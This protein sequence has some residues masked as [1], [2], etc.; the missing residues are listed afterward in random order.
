M[1]T[2][3][4]VGYI[5]ANSDLVVISDIYYLDEQWV[6]P[7][8]AREGYVVD[9][10][11]DEEVCEY[12]AK[13]Q[14]T[15]AIKQ[16]PDGAWRLQLPDQMSAEVVRRQAQDY[17]DQN[18]AKVTIELHSFGTSRLKGKDEC[19]KTGTGMVRAGQTGFAA[20]KVARGSTIEVREV[21]D[22]SGELLYVKIVP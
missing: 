14:T 3:T 7:G 10:S 18:E 2:E 19:R 21:R 16:L 5:K 11:G 15:Y 6:S 9:F 8:Q 17:V 1:P 20:L 13:R 22:A 12:L 4:T